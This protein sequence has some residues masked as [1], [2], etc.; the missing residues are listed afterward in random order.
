[1]T[2]T[3]NFKKQGGQ[4]VRG[5]VTG[6]M[7]NSKLLIAYT[8]ASGEA[9][10]RWLAKSRYDLDSLEGGSLDSVPR[11]KTVRCPGVTFE[12]PLL[13]ADIPVCPLCGERHK[14]TGLVHTLVPWTEGDDRLYTQ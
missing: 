14:G 4:V 10:E 7:G 9:R 2:I 13:P 12:Q 1:M 11:Y 3:I 8:I 6:R 5:T